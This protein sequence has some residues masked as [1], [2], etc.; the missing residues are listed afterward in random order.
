MYSFQEKLLF[1]EKK[2]HADHIFNFQATAFEELFFDTKN[3]ERINAIYFKTNETPKGEILYFH[4]N[5]GNLDRWGTYA[6][7]FTKQG[8]N[9][10]MLDYRGY[11]KSEGKPSEANFYEDG[12]LAYDW[13]RQKAK[14]SDLII[15]GRSIGTGVACQIA[16]NNPAKL[17]ILETPFNNMND[18]A[19]TRFPYLFL[20]F[21]LRHQFPND[22]H[23]K[24]VAYPVLIFHGTKDKVVPYECA[25]K[26]KLELKET[27][28]FYTIENGGHNNL[29]QF[30]IFNKTIAT[31]LQ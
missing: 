8:Y 30:E 25:A 17:L 4:G 26:L 27:D 6:D 9:I 5:A 13:I 14:A 23:I 28:H 22:E 11:G 10:L 1:L 2:L 24:K 18:V 15:Y 29:N 31:I 7:R 20:P 3:G 21:P 16:A 12:Q 19:R